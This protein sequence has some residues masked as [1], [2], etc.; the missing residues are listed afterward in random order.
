M[1]GHP[2]VALVV[3]AIA[4]AVRD[5]YVPDV[6]SLSTYVKQVVG[7]QRAPFARLQL[8]GSFEL[9]VQIPLVLGEPAPVLPRTG[10]VVDQAQRSPLAAAV[11][12]I[13]TVEGRGVMHQQ[14]AGL[15]ANWLFSLGVFG[16]VVRDALRETENIGAGVGAQATA[17]RPWNVT[18][19]AIGFSGGVERQPHGGRFVRF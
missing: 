9:L 12:A 1:L 14:V 17:M 5:Q 18:Q 19:A 2:W 15:G 8:A 11:I 3:K 7:R 16:P 4:R 10:C 13:S 6:E